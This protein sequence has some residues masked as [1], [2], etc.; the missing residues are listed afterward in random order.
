MKEK[1]PKKGENER[2]K[3]RKNLERKKKK[4]K[5]PKNELPSDFR[6]L[7]RH[8]PSDVDKNGVKK[9]FFFECSSAIV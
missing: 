7:I 5:E 1:K 8:K 9:K 6:C 2:M 3:K 4:Q